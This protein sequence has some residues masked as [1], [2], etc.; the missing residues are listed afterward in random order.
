[1]GKL[2]VSQRTYRH[3]EIAGSIL[4]AAKLDKVNT[5]FS[6][7]VGLR[8]YSGFRGNY[9]AILYEWCNTESLSWHLVVDLEVERAQS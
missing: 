5:L 7:P 4:Q 2:V 3:N 1:M 9:H 6:R 8:Y